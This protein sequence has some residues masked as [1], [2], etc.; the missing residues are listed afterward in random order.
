M[1]NASPSLPHGRPPQPLPQTSNPGGAGTGRNSRAQS[2]LGRARTAAQNARNGH[3]C[4][5]YSSRPL[6]RRS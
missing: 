2:R 3:A 4:C 1:A 6:A 5:S